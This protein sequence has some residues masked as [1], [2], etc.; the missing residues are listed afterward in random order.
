MPPEEYKGNVRS[1]I[2][3]LV[4]ENPDQMGWLLGSDDEGAHFGRWGLDDEI[5]E[6]G[7]ELRRELEEEGAVVRQISD[8]SLGWIGILYDLVQENETAEP[9][10]RLILE[11]IPKE[12]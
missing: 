11:K 5:E 2:Y 7:R 3:E 10:F 8:T 9:P 12:E 6:E 4:V 1:M